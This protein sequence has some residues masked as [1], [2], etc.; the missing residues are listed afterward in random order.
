MVSKIEKVQLGNLRSAVEKEKKHRRMTEPRFTIQMDSRTKKITLSYSVPY[1][2]GL[3]NKNNRIVK[4]KQTKMYL[5]N[6]S[7]NDGEIIINNLQ[8]YADEIL[9]DINLKYKSI[10]NERDT[11]FHWMRVFTENLKRRGNIEISAATQRNDK[12]ALTDLIDWC[13]QIKPKYLNI[14]NWTKDGRDVILEYFKYR[15]EIGGRPNKRGNRIQWSDSSVSS[16]YRRI[17]AHFNFIA[18]NVDGFPPQLLNNLPIKKTKII[19]ETFTSMEMNL[20]LQFM[21]AN[22][23]NPRWTWFFPMF[24]VLLETGMRVSEICS[25]KIRNVDID[26]R[27]CKIVGKGKK[28]RWVYFKSNALWEIIQKQIYD[29]KKGIRTDTDY[30]FWSTYSQQQNG[31]WYKVENKLNPISSNGLSA[32]TKKMFRELRLNEKLSTHATR[33][34]FITEMLKKTDGNIPLVAQ[35]VGQ[36]SWDVVRLYTKNVVD[37][38][39]EL[40]VGLFD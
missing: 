1:D 19:T 24:K 21:D 30:I 13:T 14:W 5:K 2:A 9:K 20:I 27:K 8:T 6:I 37:N 18:E 33:R 34:Y 22:K 16:S 23:E 36:N 11:L 3:D 4:M 12:N 17:R 25:M 29:D 39:K 7:V 40:N 35:L 15:Q 26:D 38:S 28:E 32:K 31:R 10:G